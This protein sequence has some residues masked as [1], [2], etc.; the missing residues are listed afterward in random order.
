[1][2]MQI[3]YYPWNTQTL[4]S[5]ID[6]EQAQYN[7]FEDFAQAVE[8]SSQVL[9]RWKKHLLFDIKLEQINKLAKYR[10]LSFVE[11][12]E[13]LNICKAHLEILEEGK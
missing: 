11:A 5:W 2:K 3:N 10:N 9:W 8:I 6:T 13:W 1:M 12:V 7:S 4:S